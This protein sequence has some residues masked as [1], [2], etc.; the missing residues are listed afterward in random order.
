MWNR[1]VA[2][3]LLALA[4]IAQSGLA[5]RNGIDPEKD[6]AEQNDVFWRKEQFP[7]WVLDPELCRSKSGR[8]CDPDAVLGASEVTKLE[9]K[10]VKNTMSTQHICREQGI[11]AEVVFSLALLRKVRLII[12][13]LNSCFV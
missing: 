2:P 1:I 9:H 13:G 5:F 4:T 11:S 3:L 12:L 6:A 10:L 7:D 8:V